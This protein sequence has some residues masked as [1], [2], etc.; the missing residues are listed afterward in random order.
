ESAITPRTKMLMVNFPNN[1]TGAAL[2]RSTF[3]KIVNVV[4]EYDLLLVSDEVYV[5]LSYDEEPFSFCTVP[6]IRDR[7]I[8]LHGFS[9]AWAMTGWRLGF[10]LAPADIIAAMNKIHQYTVMC[11]ST[12][13]QLA[14]IEALEHGEEATLAMKREYDRRRRYV[15]H[16]LN[17]MGLPTVEPKGAFYVFP[18]IRGTGLSSEDFALGLLKEE[19]VAVVP[20]PA[21]GE[22]GEGHIR[23]S[24]ASSMEALRKAMER[25]KSF[26][27]RHA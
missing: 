5:P 15:T 11:T 18:N 14:A 7:L 12:M 13:A 20:G 19:K 25:M 9:K 22:C 2:D 23:C 3:D 24:Y 4:L 10:A 1:P 16:A 8:L 17:E 26:V 21:F 6:E 27:G